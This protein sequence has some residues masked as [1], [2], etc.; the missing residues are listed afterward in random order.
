VVQCVLLTET[1]IF[2]KIHTAHNW[3]MCVPDFQEQVIDYDSLED[4]HTHNCVLECLVLQVGC[5]T[6]FSWKGT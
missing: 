5:D 2:L 6:L 4:R 1:H 3:E